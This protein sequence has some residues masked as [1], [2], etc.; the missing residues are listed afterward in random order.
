MKIGQSSH[1]M[2]S[3]KI[4]NFQESMT[5]LNEGAKKSLKTFL[6]TPRIYIYIYM[7]DFL[8]NNFPK[9]MVKN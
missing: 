6:K 8:E 9:A 1:N 5:I 7:F 3:N 2:Y 4:L